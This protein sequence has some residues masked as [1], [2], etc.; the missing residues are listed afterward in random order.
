[1]LTIIKKVKLRLSNGI[2]YYLIASINVYFM[3]E[4]LKITKIIKVNTNN[5]DN[6]I[7]ILKNDC[8]FILPIEKMES[9]CDFL[10]HKEN[11]SKFLKNLLYLVMTNI[12]LTFNLAKLILI[13]GIDSCSSFC[14]MFHYLI[15]FTS[16]SL[17]SKSYSLVQLIIMIIRIIFFNATYT[18]SYKPKGLRYHFIGSIFFFFFIHSIK[19]WSS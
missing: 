16:I 19:S 15:I 6:C 18:T 8:F 17:E 4:L 3:C 10:Y 7:S 13:V 5:F 11:F 9:I 2:I 12:V 14:I 1:M